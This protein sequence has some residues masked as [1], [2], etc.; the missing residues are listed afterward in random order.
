MTCSEV[1]ASPDQKLVDPCLIMK[2]H[3]ELEIESLKFT[4]SGLFVSE[5]KE[6]SS[7]KSL[8]RTIS[9]CSFVNQANPF[10]ETKDGIDKRNILAM[11]VKLMY[12]DYMT[13]RTFQK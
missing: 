13:S 11:P 7:K 6:Q 12:S 4:P 10:E 1:Y 3:S 2:N 5:E 8:N 9:R